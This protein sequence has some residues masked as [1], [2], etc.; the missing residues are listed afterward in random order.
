MDPKAGEACGRAQRLMQDTI[1]EGRRV[2]SGLR[3]PVL[4]E[5]GVIAAIEYLVHEEPW[6]EKIQ[7]ELDLPKEELEIS[8][9]L[10]TAIFR[11]AQE[12]IHNVSQHSQADHVSISL[13]TANGNVR[14]EVCDTGVGFKTESGSY[15]SFGLRGIRER[16]KI[17]G[18]ILDL[19]SSPEQGT[20]LVVEFPIRVSNWQI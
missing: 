13:S 19:D 6:E 16:V 14:L 2:I 3:P 5:L 18:G 17:H 8:S 9:D 15:K 10:G 1:R 11:I 12:A 4:D 20:R 7:I